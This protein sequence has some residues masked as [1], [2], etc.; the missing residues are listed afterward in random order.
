M[1]QNKVGKVKKVFLIVL[2]LGIIFSVSAQKFTT[3]LDGYDWVTWINSERVDYITGYMVAS[4]NV[5][6]LLQWVEYNKD[7]AGTLTE[8]IQGLI[9]GTMAWVTYSMTVGELTDRVSLYY[10]EGVDFLKFPINEV[11]LVV[12]DKDWWNWEKN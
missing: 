2:F 4:F 12:T 7:E 11:I 5:A 3:D 10:S 9:S 8:D 6:E 1:V